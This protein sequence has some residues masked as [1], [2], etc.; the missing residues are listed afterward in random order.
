MAQWDTGYAPLAVPASGDDLLIRD[1]SATP[2]S[3]GTLKRVT[4]QGLLGV[5][6]VWPSGDPT[7]AADAANIAAAVTVLGSSP[8][9][10]RL[11]AAAPWCVSCGSVTLTHS[12][13]YIDAPGCFINAKGSGDLFRM[14]DASTYTTRTVHGGGLTGYPFING[15]GSASQNGW[16]AGDIF[17]L[18]TQALFSGF[19]GTG[20]AGAVWDNQW[21]IAEQM[22]IDCWAQNCAT[23][24]L[25]TQ[26]PA[27]GNTF[28]YGS[29]MRSKI[30]LAVNQG[31]ASNNMITLANGVYL[32]GSLVEVKGNASGTNAG[33]VTTALFLAT[34]TS[35]SGSQ[36][37]TGAVS[38]NLA[39]CEMQVNVELA[40]NGGTDWTFAPT[41]FKVTG[42][43]YFGGLTGRLDFATAAGI[44]KVSDWTS[45]SAV[46]GFFGE[47]DGGD[48]AIVSQTTQA[49]LF[50]GRLC[51][52]T[53]A[54]AVVLAGSGTIS[55]TASYVQV[56]PAANVA[57]IIL[58]A[59]AYDGQQVT[60][61]NSSAF[62]VTFAIAGTSHVADGTADVI[63][64]TTARLFFWSANTGLWYRA[65]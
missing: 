17:R 6:P 24:F 58:A 23:H 35:P 65:A 21:A 20:S 27:V 26:N 60:V 46:V 11:M 48:P 38:S 61:V 50:Q 16:H 41:T 37:G 59:G 56:A 30:R 3:D 25:F 31:S 57:G 15:D 52:G 13:Q 1:V 2:P 32:P 5:I 45:T 51:T 55:T 8:G 64:A 42:S 39:D 53:Y 10:I 34:G 33:A 9:I 28:C 14:Y 54:A 19:S 40:P 36:D 29:M 12:G 47:T 63:A 22:D 44:S 62:T 4:T 7:G 49:Q 43:C 18:K